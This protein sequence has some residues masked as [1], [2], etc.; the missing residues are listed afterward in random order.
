MTAA[1][2]LDARTAGAG[3]DQSRVAELSLARLTDRMTYGRALEYADDGAVVE[4]V[5]LEGSIRLKGRVTGSRRNI[6]S[7]AVSFDQAPSGMVTSLTGACSCPMAG[8]CKH[9]FALAIT[10]FRD[11]SPRPPDDAGGV[12]ATWQPPAPAAL[13]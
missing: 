4:L 2:F 13:A 6:Y 8:N 11:G 12:P 10:A 1:P 9:V 3:R 7:G 5:L